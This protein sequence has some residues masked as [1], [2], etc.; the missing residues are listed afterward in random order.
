MIRDL[1]VTVALCLLLP[2]LL[3]E[4]VYGSSEKFSSLL[5]KKK[6]WKI[7]PYCITAQH[8]N[9][10]ASW[11]QGTQ[12]YENLEVLLKYFLPLLL[13]NTRTLCCCTASPFP[14][15]CFDF[16]PWEL[17]KYLWSD[18]FSPL[19]LTLLIHA[20]T[21]IWAKCVYTYCYYDSISYTS[22]KPFSQ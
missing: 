10:Q 15:D 14:P 9:Y 12:V 17:S 3:P 22:F 21:A 5:L 11:Y 19:I 1:L 6:F 7:E 20:F 18:F 16:F 8:R 13:P 2:H 4:N